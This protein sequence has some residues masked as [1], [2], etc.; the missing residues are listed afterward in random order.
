MTVR[1]GMTLLEVIV[2]LAVAGAA[3]AAG[4]AV[5]GFLTDQ[6]ERSGAL[7]VASA[8]AA[9]TTLRDWVA[10]AQLTTQG[11]AEFRGTSASRLMSTAN[12][13]L[14]FVTTAPTPIG[15]TGT[16]VHLH[17]TA[18]GLIANLTSWRG[19]GTTS[20]VALAP[21]ATG[22]RIRY[23]G[24]I[25]GER[26][27]ERTWATTSVLPVAAEI[28]IQFDGASRDRAAQSLLGVPM[29]VEFG[30]RR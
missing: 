12:D 25:Y 21:D 3:L 8:N 1:K 10:N 16:V 5:L 9:R 22:L 4:A 23:L 29:T 20:A 26:R 30:S 2:A 18:R 11:D 27:W 19:S 15:E 28:T 17:V 7:P 24:S 14:T 13:E 6:Q